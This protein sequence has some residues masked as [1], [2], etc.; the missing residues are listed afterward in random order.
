MGDR[1]CVDI[2]ALL[3]AGEGML[4]GNFAAGFFLVQSETLE[5]AYISSRP[6]RVNAGA[7]SCYAVAPAGKTAYLTELK[8]GSEVRGHR[9]V[10]TGPALACLRSQ[11]CSPHIALLLACHS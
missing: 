4:L 10:N 11:P 2:A 6:F 9:L 7:V 8:S 3:R 5:S 1:A